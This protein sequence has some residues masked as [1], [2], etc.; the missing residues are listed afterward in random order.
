[1][2]TTTRT[3]TQTITSVESIKNTEELLTLLEGT[4]YTGR[5]NTNS[6]TILRGIIHPKGRKPN[7]AGRGFL[8]NDKVIIITE[9]RVSIQAK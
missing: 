1:M 2:D 3:I 5:I 9:G 8:T 6:D 4:N 7:G